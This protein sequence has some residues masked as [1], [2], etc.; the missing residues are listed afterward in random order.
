MGHDYKMI[1]TT[2]GY[3]D[4]G[5]ELAWKKS[6]ACI[7]HRKNVVLDSNGKEILPLSL[8]EQLVSPQVCS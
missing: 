4:C 1:S 3:C 2:G 8:L 7:H 5:D 6:G